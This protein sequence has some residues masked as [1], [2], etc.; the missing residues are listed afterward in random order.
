MKD[1]F[2]TFDH[3]TA[4][5]QR[6]RFLFLGTRETSRRPLRAH[7]SKLGHG[8]TIAVRFEDARRQLRQDGADAIVLDLVAL[9]D[10]GLNLIRNLR[11]IT[12]A[13]ILVLTDGI[14]E[15]TDIIALKFGADLCLPQTRSEALI[16]ESLAAL[17]RRNEMAS[18]DGERDRG[19][20][21]RGDLVMNLDEFTVTWKQIPIAL[22]SSEFAVLQLLVERPGHLR[23]RAQ[24]QAH[25]HG[26]NMH[27][28]ER[29]VDSHIKRIRRK[30]RDADPSFDAID[31]LYGLGYRFHVED[32]TRLA[33]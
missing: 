25:V 19:L 6:R 8:V 26:A 10:T 30:M 16:A 31:T 24:I 22:T 4:A 12:P 33:S 15:V 17:L 23:S 18:L 13:P 11:A 7:L 20:L 2:E 3:D 29:T 5:N 21:I 14:T 1:F 9:G 28:F 27:F 32:Q